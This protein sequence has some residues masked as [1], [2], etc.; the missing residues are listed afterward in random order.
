MLEQIAAHWEILTFIAALI[1]NAGVMFH[2]I[3]TKPGET[4]VKE[5]I[6][7]AFDNHCPFSAKIDELDNWKTQRI[8]EIKQ[9]EMRQQQQLDTIIIHLKQVCSKLEIEWQNPSL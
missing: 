3:K 8:K 9:S 4:R 1:F 2:T 7:E 5:M 6:D